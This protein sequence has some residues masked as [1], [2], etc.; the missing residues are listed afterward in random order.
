MLPDSTKTTIRKTLLSSPAPKLI[1]EFAKR[2]FQLDV[3]NQKKLPKHKDGNVMFV[4]NHTAFF[5]LEVYLIGSVL[6]ANDKS[7]DLR[8]LVWEGFSEGPLGDWFTTLG[9]ET[10]R[11]SRGVELLNE[12]V[13]VLIMPEGVDATDVRNKFNVFHTGYL[14][15][16]QGALA[17]GISVD[18]IPIGFA[19][20][21]EAIPW[22]VSNNEFLVNNVMKGVDPNFDFFL[23]PKLPAPRPTKIV[24]NVGDAIT[25]TAEDL[26]TEEK[27]KA[28]NQLIRD[29]VE[30]LVD[31]A[32][33][34]R[35]A[36]IQAN[37]VNQWFHKIV[38]GKI[39][40]LPF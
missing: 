8:T 9:A 14:R 10:A 23:L 1:T 7:L 3:L 31:E 21:D 6:Y 13:S 22:W 15:M 30:A 20:V 37:P 19:G 40:Q 34:H 26:A 32:A 12:G 28:H 2:Y 36:S 16:I 38:G 5:A 33:A 27:L 4:M 17:E 11:I 24:Y 39:S 35:A 25:L 29:G 18:I